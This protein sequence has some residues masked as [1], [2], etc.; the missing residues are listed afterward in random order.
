[1]IKAAII[2]LLFLCLPAQAFQL[3]GGVERQEILKMN[4]VSD[5]TSGLGVSDA[6]IAIPSKG[7]TTHTD[8]SGLFELPPNLSP[9][10]VL[11]VNKKGYEPFSL[12]VKSY[13]DAP[14]NLMITKNSAAKVAIEA[15]TFHLGDNSYSDKSANAGDFRSRSIGSL[16]E[17]SFFV[18]ALAPSE[19]VHLVIGSL[20]GVDTKEA[21]RL[22]QTRVTDAYSSSVKVFVNSN[23]VANLKI[24]GDNQKINIP[25]TFLRQNA[26]NII[27]I[28][29]GINQTQQN[30]IDY[31]DFEF[32]NLF[33]EYK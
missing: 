10:F 25:K 30:Y 26:K 21:R 13:G 29:A 22:G 16:Y 19:N 20:I 14:F 18:K 23:Q 4:T 11:S 5:N 8:S 28:V 15:D 3:N 2:L 7:Y 9:P 31:D 33:L 24:N 17:K 32:T 6:K 1:M 27:K 12:T